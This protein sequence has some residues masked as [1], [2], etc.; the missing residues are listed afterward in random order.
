M[1]DVKTK[2]DI[3]QMNYTACLNCTSVEKS[4]NN[5]R[6]MSARSLKKNSQKYSEKLKAFATFT[7][8]IS[9][10]VGF[11]FT[12]TRNSTDCEVLS[13]GVFTYKNHSLPKGTFCVSA[14]VEW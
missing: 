10:H 2:L 3:L 12:Y 14:R 13:F 1:S 5:K 11:F 8:G 4:E 9:R 7:T 6:A